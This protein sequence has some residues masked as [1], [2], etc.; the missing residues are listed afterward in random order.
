LTVAE[1]YFKS[2]LDDEPERYAEACREMYEKTGNTTY[3]GLGINMYLGLRQGELVAL[4]VSDF[5]NGTV[6]VE[7]MEIANN[8]M[9]NGKLKQRGYKIVPF[10]KTKDSVRNVPVISIAKGFYEEM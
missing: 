4:K 10:T 5:R 6:R 9:E 3:V 7:R 2:Y 8:I 1:N